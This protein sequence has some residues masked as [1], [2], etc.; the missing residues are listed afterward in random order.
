MSK[1]FLQLFLT[2]LLASSCQ[3]IALAGEPDW[4][5]FE[6]DDRPVE[7]ISHPDW[8]KESFLDLK[9]DLDEAISA[10]KKGIAVYFGQKNCAYCKALMKND[11]GQDDIAA[12]TQKNF[13]VISINIWG[14]NEVTAP[15]GAVL[16]EREYAMREKANLTPSLIFYDKD[17]EKSLM[18]RGYYPPYKFR[19]ALEYVV[20]GYY[21]EETL[22]N[23]LTRA[24]PPPK[25][26]VGD[27]NSDELFMEPP[28][29]LDR[30]RMKAQQPL[31][32]IFEQ[33]DCHACDVLHSSPL[34]HEETRSLLAKF[35]IV[36]LDMNS[37]SPVL[38]PQGKKLTAKQWAEQ[39][40]LFYAPTLI[41]F[42]EGG[43]EI[44]RLDSVAHAYRLKSVLQYVVSKNYI[45]T[46]DFMEWR[47]DVIF[48]GK[49]L[50]EM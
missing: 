1:N 25:F 8:F 21:Q 11:F 15:D 6:F 34:Q 19:A 13:D 45:D 48:G 27:L 7:D 47:F 32:V 20:E 2:I 40:E 14:S 29:M 38:T 23:Y 12:Y 18:L 4:E 42:D 24:D 16:T 26:E 31:L 35:D 5:N 50:P 39:L 37:D 36:Q 41:A 22:R 17:G 43:K 44:I 28:Y 9:E 30:S 3:P 49:K 46:P 33:F 10:G